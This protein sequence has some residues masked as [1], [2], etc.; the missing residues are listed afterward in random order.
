[1]LSNRRTFNKIIATIGGTFDALHKGHKEY[2]Q[3][4]LTFSDH[5]IIYLK[6]SEY[7][8][9]YKSKSY[10][11]RSYSERYDNLKKFVF[12]LDDGN[13]FEIRPHDH[14]NDFTEDYLS[15][16]TDENTLYMAVVSP[17]YYDNFLKIN[18][19]REQ[20]GL[21]S[22]ILMVKPR[23]CEKLPNGDPVEISSGGIRNKC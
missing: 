16:F 8:K 21:D 11:I 1:M 12:G 17:E 14:P 19:S 22:I 9:A 4:A 3:I 13:R 18:E 6:T 10:E 15:E 5:L 20:K 23:Y 2:I 7:I